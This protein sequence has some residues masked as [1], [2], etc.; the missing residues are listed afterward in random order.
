MDIMLLVINMLMV[1]FISVMAVRGA[2]PRARPRP[3]HSIFSEG[4]EEVLVEGG[5]DDEENDPDEPEDP[6]DKR[7]RFKRRGGINTETAKF[8][9]TGIKFEAREKLFILK[10]WK[11]I[12]NYWKLGNCKFFNDGRRILKKQYY[13]ERPKDVRQ[14][15]REITGV[16]STTL[17]SIKNKMQQDNEKHGPEGWVMPANRDRGGHKTALEAVLPDM[18]LFIRDQII[19]ARKGGHLTVKLLAERATT[20]F[21]CRAPIKPKRMKRTLNR[22]GYEYN[23]R[24]GVYMNRRH[25][26]ANLQT[27]KEFCQFVKDNVD[28]D[29]ETGLYYFTI[30]IAFGDGANEYT[31]AFRPRSWMLRGHPVLGTCEKSRKKDSGQRLN[32]LGAIYSNSF[33][34]KSFTA[35]NS[36]DEGKN[37]YAKNED[38]VDHTVA[39]VL[40]NL[41]RGTGAVYVLDNAS[42]NKK[43]EDGVR[44]MMSDKIHDWINHHDPD[45]PRFQEYWSEHSE[46]AT[47][48]TARK[49]MLMQYIRA[50]IDEFTE[51]ALL[52][53]DADVK[54]RYLPKYFPECNPIE[55]VWAQIK[56]EYKAT[57]SS[58]KWRARLDLAHEKVSEE[59]IEKCFDRSIRYCLD[60]LLEFNATDDVH[61]GNGGEAGEIQDDLGDNEWVNDVEEDHD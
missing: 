50:N 5:D 40:P 37:N 19:A 45:P 6:E 41:P 46:A 59:F 58:L 12:E 13:R 21:D 29:E 42:N 51:L 2:R 32:M 28:R 4:L 43:I 11:N 3:I 18:D 38:I 15:F 24:K 47:A 25:D 53:R 16:S 55:L 44:T 56:R 9:G 22:L 49:K 33:D 14:F 39:H 23:E 17:S 54:I 26:P 48:E 34:M 10:I 35:W 60:R 30:P 36:E 8:S 57:D 31:K 52:L 7:R 1:F 61:G 27:L 20:Y